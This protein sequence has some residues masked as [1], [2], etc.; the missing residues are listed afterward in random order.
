MVSSFDKYDKELVELR[1]LIARKREHFPELTP[2]ECA[3][4]AIEELFDPHFEPNPA[5]RAWLLAHLSD[6]RSADK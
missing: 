2:Q 6:D 1:Q 4:A 3:H 5:F